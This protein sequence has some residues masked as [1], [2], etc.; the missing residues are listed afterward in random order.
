[1][2]ILDHDS[3]PFFLFAARHSSASLIET[4][5]NDLGVHPDSASKIGRTMM[6]MA[7]FR[8]HVKKLKTLADLGADVNKADNNGRTIMPSNPNEP[9]ST[10]SCRNPDILIKIVN[11]TQV[12]HRYTNVHALGTYQRWSCCTD[13]ERTSIVLKI[14]AELLHLLR[15]VRAIAIW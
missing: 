2:S 11:C 7:S 6:I 8:G 3:N 13:S 10:Q 1:M 4:V 5:V 15:P 12:G 14:T 9:R